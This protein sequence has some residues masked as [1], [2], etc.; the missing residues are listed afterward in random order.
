MPRVFCISRRLYKK[1]IALGIPMAVLAAH[2]QS[3]TIRLENQV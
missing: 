2:S 3:M 1:W